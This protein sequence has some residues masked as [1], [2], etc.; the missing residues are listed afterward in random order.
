MQS[1]KRIVR[2]I[3]PVGQGAFYLETFHMENGDTKRVIYDC[4]AAKK[5]LIEKTIRDLF[6]ENTVIDKVFISHFH[7]ECLNGLEYLMRRCA[8]KEL[9]LPYVR[10]ENQFYTLM[11]N[12]ARNY[13]TYISYIYNLMNN[14]VETVQRF[15]EKRNMNTDVY[16]VN[17]VSYDGEQQENHINSGTVISIDEDT[18]EWVYIPY[19]YNQCEN[20]V[21]DNIRIKKFIERY[22][23]DIDYLTPEKVNKVFNDQGF[24]TN[25]KRIYSDYELQIDINSMTVYSGPVSY[26]DYIVRIPRLYHINK[27]CEHN[28]YRCGLDGRSFWSYRAGALYLGILNADDNKFLDLMRELREKTNMKPCESIGILQIPNY[29]SKNNYSNAIMELCGRECWYFANAAEDS[30]YRYPNHKVLLDFIVNGVDVSIVTE[31]MEDALHFIIEK[32]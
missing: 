16:I 30:K 31:S 18:K 2:S 14:P 4:G 21:E 27:Y 10:K 22:V 12:G 11:E 20:G 17:E 26:K 19:N 6:D 8:V 9:Y 7:A 3:L 25:L 15:N 1:K 29:G 32:Y 13:G 5:S 24:S 23:D 28:N